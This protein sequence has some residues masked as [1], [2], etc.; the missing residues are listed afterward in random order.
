MDVKPLNEDV[1]FHCMS[2]WQKH[3]DGRT[4]AY[5]ARLGIWATLDSDG[6]FTLECTR[7]HL[8]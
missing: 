2:H 4:C 7:K 6:R 3:D 8:K 1:T 5:H